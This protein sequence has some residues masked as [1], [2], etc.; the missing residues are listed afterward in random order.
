MPPSRIARSDSTCTSTPLPPSFT[1]TP[2]AFQKRE[3]SCTYLSNGARTKAWIVTLDAMSPRSQPSTSPTVRSRKKIGEPRLIEP[4]RS[5]FSR[6]VRPGTSE[7]STGGSSSPTKSRFAVPPPLS[8][9]RIW[10]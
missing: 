9:G 8:D 2:E 7:S 4:S 10:M 5:A 1:L 3:L 6:K